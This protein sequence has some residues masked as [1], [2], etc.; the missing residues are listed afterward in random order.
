MRYA[1]KQKKK[2]NLVSTL[3]S[4]SQLFQLTKEDVLHLNVNY[5]KKWKD[6]TKN[7]KKTFASISKVLQPIANAI[8]QS[9]EILLQTMRAI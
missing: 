7:L 6:L 9:T 8:Q 4:E 2:H 1:E 5:Y 3:S